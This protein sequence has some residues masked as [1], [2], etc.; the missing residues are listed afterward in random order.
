VAAY[1]I[2][3]VRERPGDALFD[4][5]YVPGKV[6]LLAASNIKELVLTHGVFGLAPDQEPPLV[7]VGPLPPVTVTWK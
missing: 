6:R 4:L 3:L 1:G 5:E 7:P 2:R